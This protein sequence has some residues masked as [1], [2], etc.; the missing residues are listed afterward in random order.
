MNTILDN[1]TL[2]IR[3]ALAVMHKR[4]ILLLESRILNDQITPSTYRRVKAILPK[5]SK[6]IY[7]IALTGLPLSY[8]NPL[9]II[10][11]TAPLMPIILIPVI[12]VLWNNI[13]SYEIEQEIPILLSYILPYTPTPRYIT[14][15]IKDIPGDVFKWMRGEAERLKLR[16]E[17]GDDPLNALRYLAETTPSKRL[18]TI[19][20]DYITSQTLGASRSQITLTLLRHAI[21]SIRDTWRKYSELGRIIGELTT[22]II[23]A[24][25]AIAPITILTGAGLEGLALLS[26]LAPL[27]GGLGLILVRPAVGEPPVEWWVTSLLL[28]APITAST[29]LYMGY[30][31]PSIILLLAAGVVGEYKWHIV[32][33]SLVGGV[34]SLRRASDAIKYGGEY[35]EYLK[36]AEKSS[37]RLVKALSMSLRIAG[38]LGVSPALSTIS[39]VQEEVVKAISNVRIQSVILSALAIGAV[40]I[41]VYTGDI[42]HG[43]LKSMETNTDSTIIIYRILEASAPIAPLPASILYRGRV[44]SMVPSIASILG[45]ML[46]TR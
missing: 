44:P 17:L 13:K 1:V 11:A 14:D 30:T 8:I 38:K 40:V 20:N 3:N 12:V 22:T 45:L 19:L 32:Y 26:I 31:I 25:A 21:D 10:L 27:V 41:G 37:G 6:A 29:L 5:L 24:S 34:D 36:E 16:L 33:K 18:K 4:Y 46:L 35:E 15:L 2:N 28:L 7:I 23:I 43:A 42:I 39:H 9:L